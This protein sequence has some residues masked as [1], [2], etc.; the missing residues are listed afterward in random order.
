MSRSRLGSTSRR[1]NRLTAGQDPGLIKNQQLALVGSGQLL[2]R[3]LRRSRHTAIPGLALQLGSVDKLM[4]LLLKV[5]ELHVHFIVPGGVKVH[6]LNGASFDL[7]HGEVLG[8]LG[9][10]GSGKST[11]ARALM[12]LS[13]NAAHI[14]K[15]AV[16]FEGRDL[17]ALAEAE[18][19]RVRGAQLSFISQ[20]PGQ[21]L[22]PVM[23]V[24]DQ[25]AEVVHAHRDWG[26]NRCK[27]EAASLLERVNLSSH[28]RRVYEAYPHQLSGG[29]QQRVV[30]AQ[31]LACNPLLIIADEP[32]ASLDSST[33]CEIL[34]LFRKLKE[35][36]ELSLLLITHDPTI[37]RGLADRVAVMYG[38]RIVEDGPLREIYHR[39]RHP[40]VRSLLDCVL[41]STADRNSAPHIRLKTIPGSSPDS[42]H[43]A[44]GCSFSPR[45]SERV[46]KCET[47]CPSS[48][49]VDPEGQV[50]CFLY[51]G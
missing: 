39:P 28:S 9:E 20:D 32:T 29:Q 41:P 4:A 37:L 42:I 40:Y 8:I 35:E 48:I 6:A 10:S 11:L 49:E 23:R 22:S 12:R 7:E 27:A 17:L 13:P 15:G 14:S 25:I 33:A 3:R 16:Q 30:I 19:G 43:M 18:I 45:C 38:G 24:G 2:K 36:R 5:E 47:N 51:G 46:E 44:K 31:A 26:W 21:A 50:E 1:Q 34:E